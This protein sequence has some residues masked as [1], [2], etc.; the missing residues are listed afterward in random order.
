MLGSSVPDRR[1]CTGVSP[2]KGCLDDEE[3]GASDTQ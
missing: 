1:G 3:L 2:A